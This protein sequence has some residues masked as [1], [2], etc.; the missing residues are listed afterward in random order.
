MAPRRWILGLALSIATA[1]AQN[2]PPA[3]AELERAFNAAETLMKQ[4]HVAEAATAYE[5][6]VRRWPEVAELRFEL[7]VTYVQLG[8]LHD[9]AEAFRSYLKLEPSSADGHA[10][11]GVVLLT[12]GRVSEARP[13]LETALRLDRTQAE[14]A[15]ALARVYNIQGE[16]A[17][18]IPLLR[19]TVT[20]G[21]ADD[22][23]RAI[24]AR[25]LYS[26]GDPAGASALLDR[27]LDSETKPALDTYVLAA[28]AARDAQD[29]PKA[30]RICE[31][32][33]RAYPNSER[34]EALY[35]SLPKEQ[36]VD[37]INA[38]LAQLRQNPKDVEEMINV[39]RAMSA[40]GKGKRGPAVERGEELLALV[41]QLQPGNAIAW[42]HY[43]R[44]LLTQ[45]KL[46]EARK[47]FDKALGLVHDNELKT[48]VLD[49]IALTESRQEHFDPADQA[50]RESLGLN[51]KLEHPIPEPAFE[52]Y[53]F[54]IARER[55][56]EA[57][58]L[59]EEIL[60]WQ[61]L[62]GPA[63][64]ERAKQFMNQEQPAKGI[65][66]A[67]LVTRN[68]EDPELQ[69]SAHFLLVKIYRMLGRNDDAQVHADW[70][71]AHH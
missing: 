36:L 57:R 34:I 61:P 66:D 56:T 12:G 35:V 52:Y 46:D 19:A 40:A 2:A 58:S 41:V 7:A 59:L 14:A 42:Y 18:A 53:W 28:A 26:S 15:K 8:R 55:E 51:R 13:E 17:K 20:S 63:L 71:K 37:R 6:L 29:I 38:R 39:G 33:V 3:G 10:A 54:L 47:A 68:A 5:Q 30:M 16:S 69:R 31:Q 25:S 1:A 48:L 43:G 60:L 70:I 50:F 21:Q 23:A 22:E 67:L 24:Y 44:C 64:L 11:L 32:G 62:F 27:M 49:R 4:G 45:L 9:A 65:E